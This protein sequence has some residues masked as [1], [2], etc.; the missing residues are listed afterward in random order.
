[1]LRTEAMWIPANFLCAPS[2]AWSSAPN[3][4]GGA[5]AA[6]GEEKPGAPLPR[7][8]LYEHTIEPLAHRHSHLATLQFCSRADNKPATNKLS[9][10]QLK[11]NPP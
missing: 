10:S 7:R 9:S 6:A 5:L 3:Q 1:V 4:R 8:D 2:P 11:G